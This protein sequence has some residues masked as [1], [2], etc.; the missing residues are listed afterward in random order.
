MADEGYKRKLTAV[1]IADV[2]GYGR[3]VGEDEA[4]TAISLKPTAGHVP[5]DQTAPGSFNRCHLTA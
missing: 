5:P 1:F 4:P 2:A 3:L